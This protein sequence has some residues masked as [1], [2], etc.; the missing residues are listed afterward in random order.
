MRQGEVLSEFGADFGGAGAGCRSAL[1][2]LCTA[3]AKQR[4]IGA[5]FKRSIA[6]TRDGRVVGEAQGKVPCAPVNTVAQAFADEQVVEDEMV[7][8][9]S[10]PDF[11]TVRQ[12]ASPVKISDYKKEHQR[13]PK[14]GEHTEEVLGEHL[15]LSHEEIEALRT[16]GVL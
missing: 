8:A 7:L 16:E 9:M 15:G 11:G 6:K 10:H 2:Q 5:A 12:V 13:G 1:L 4:S 3:A 14:L